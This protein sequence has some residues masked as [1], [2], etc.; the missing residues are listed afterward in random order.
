[1]A[2]ETDRDAQYEPGTTSESQHGW[3]LGLEWIE[4]KKDL[5]AAAGWATLSSLVSIKDDAT[6]R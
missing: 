2:S 6:S 1:M 3:A 5:V 4:S